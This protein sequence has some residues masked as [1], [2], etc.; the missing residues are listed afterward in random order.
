MPTW[1]TDLFARY[2]YAVVFGGVFLE[3][4]GLPVPGETVLLAG[5][6]L[7][8]AGHLSLTWVIATAILAAICGDNLGFLIG[9]KGGRRI[10][11]TYGR[12]VGLTPVRLREFD[13]FF[14][15]HGAK[16]VFVA[17]FITGLRVVCAVL[18]GGSSM[19]WSTF[20]FFNATGAV[21]WSCTIAMAGYSLAYSWDTLERWIGGAG[22]AGLAA[23]VAIGIVSLLRARGKC[24]S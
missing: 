23:V 3:N 2:G 8:H 5:G 12:H 7:A 20:V 6:A 22:L 13:D 14:E 18:A 16:T 10:A 19:S 24:Q 15:H 21:V 9:R 17:R 11:E 4:T 1:L